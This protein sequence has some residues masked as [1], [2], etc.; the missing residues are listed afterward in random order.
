MGTLSRLNALT[1]DH[2]LLSGPL[3]TSLTAL[4]TLTLLSFDYTSLCE[5]DNL[6]V[7]TWL[8]QIRFLRSPSCAARCPCLAPFGLMTI[9]IVA[10]ILL[11]RALPGVL[12]TLGDGNG[13]AVKGS[14]VTLTDGAGAYRFEIVRPGLYLLTVAD[15]PGLVPT[16]AVSIG[17]YLTGPD[18]LTIAPIGFY[19]LSEKLYFPLLRH[20]FLP[21]PPPP[22]PHALPSS[23]GE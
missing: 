15:P 17:F 10:G 22:P 4:T 5:P 21:P 14:R 7:Q 13:N 23:G 3:P 18:P 16:T 1:L 19:P 12:V 11:N 6:A 2:T 8:S 9:G 20:E